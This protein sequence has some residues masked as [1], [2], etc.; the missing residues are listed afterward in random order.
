MDM[1]TPAVLLRRRSVFC[2]LVAVFGCAMAFAFATTPTSLQGATVVDAAKAKSLMEAGAV[3]IDARVANEYAESHIKGAK[4]IPYKEKSEKTVAYDSTVDSF[5]LSKL[6]GDKDTP[7]IF[8]CNGPECWKSYKA[9]CAAIKAGYKN[10]YW[11]R[12]GLP[13]WEAKGYPLE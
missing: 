3:M 1:K 12:G 10:V 6:P 11:L 5:D 9:T 4:S 13:E 8:G 7:I 2:A